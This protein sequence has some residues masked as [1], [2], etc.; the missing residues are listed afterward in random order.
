M[1]CVPPHE[2]ALTRDKLIYD[3]KFKGG[4]HVWTNSL[5]NDI[6]NS[7]GSLIKRLLRDRLFH[8]NGGIELPRNHKLFNIVDRK[9]QQLYVG[10]IINHYDEKYARGM[11]PK[12]Y[13]HLNHQGAQV[14]TLKHLEAGFVIWLVSLTF[15]FVAF[16]GEWIK[17]KVD[18]ELFERTRRKMIQRIIRESYWN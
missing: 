6:P 1:A 12:V 9:L 4:I 2:Y 11:D 14:L 8:Q 5:Y 3:P 7:N 15:A 13:E 17:K 10:G 18:D 16:L